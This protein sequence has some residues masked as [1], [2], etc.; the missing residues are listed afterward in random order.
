MEGNFKHVTYSYCEPL[1]IPVYVHTQINI[2][3][4]PHDNLKILN[5]SR[6]LENEK[7]T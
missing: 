5:Y 3:I 4:N 6:L 7:I 2:Q 1:F